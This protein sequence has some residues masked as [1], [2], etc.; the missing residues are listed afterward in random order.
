MKN[1]HTPTLF[2]FTNT[3]DNIISIL[4]NGL[5]YSYC[6]EELNNEY[7]LGIPMISFCDIPISRSYEHESKYGSYAIGL[8]KSF[9]IQNTNIAPVNYFLRDN[10]INPSLDARKK[11]I[12]S[13]N[14]IQELCEQQPTSEESPIMTIQLAING[15][16]KTYPL[17]APIGNNSN[18]HNFIMNTLVNNPY[19][20]NI[21]GYL[22]K[23]ESMYKKR[24]QCNYDECEWRTIIDENRRMENSK[25]CKWFWNGDE[26][27]NWKTTNQEQKYINDYPVKFSINDI[28][29]II[30][31]TNDLIPNFMRKIA[32]L[33]HICGFEMNEKEKAILYSKVISFEQIK[34]NF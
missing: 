16:Y 1:T 7:I 23:Y 22:K 17:N 27:D 29:F 12:E 5:K 24:L 34:E 25:P 21:L 15:E 20:S 2:H 10:Q 11:Y 9:L 4:K 13:L 19:N 26:Y 31:G 28:N 33:T 18:L 30:V 8:S 32:K 6:K 3:G 14:K